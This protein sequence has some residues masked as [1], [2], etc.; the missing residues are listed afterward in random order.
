MKRAIVGY[1]RDEHQDW[2]AELE[3]GHGQHVRHRP[4]FQMRPWTLT[5]KGRA[6]RL[7]TIL[8][9]VIC[10][11]VSLRRDECPQLVNHPARFEF[12]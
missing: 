3:C 10:D 8:D 11:R 12:D 9:C 7:G 1:H 2:V 5:A 6:E 4:P